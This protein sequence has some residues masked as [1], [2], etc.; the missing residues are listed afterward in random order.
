VEDNTERK[1]QEQKLA[2][3]TKEYETVFQGTQDAM[4]LIEAVGKTTF[5]YLRNNRAHAEATGFTLEEL[6][7]KTPQELLG[8]ELGAWIAAN[9]ARCLQEGGPISY[10]ETLSLPAGTKT[11]LTTLTPLVDDDGIYIVGASQDITARKEAEEK[12]RYLSFHDS[13]TGVYN[14]RF[15]EKKMC[16][17]NSSSKS[18]PISVVMADLNGLKLINDTYGH[19]KGDA[20]LKKAAEILK[21]SSRREDILG[22]WG[23]DEFVLILP[24]T[25]EEEAEQIIK[26]IKENARGVQVEEVPLSFALGF[27]AKTNTEE[28]LRDILNQA[29]EK[30]YRQ[31]LGESKSTRS[32]LLR[33]L[34][35]ALQDK[36]HK[37]K[38]HLESMEK[39][40]LKL[41][42]SLALPETEINRLK[43]L[44]L[45]H[46]I[47][48]ISVPEEIL[49]KKEALTEKEREIIKKHPETGYRIVRATEE[50]SHIAEDILSHHERW[51]GTGYPRK[52][53]GEEIPLLARI[54]MLVDAYYAL[55]SES[56]NRKALSEKE[57]AAELKKYAGS[58][59]D[60]KLVEILT[61]IGVTD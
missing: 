21:N 35:K 15:L 14:R 27:A 58:Q 51:D 26:R 2:K 34:L 3:I 22:R 52:L 9:Y 24:Q 12:I 60:P 11:W 49:N 10:E 23:G 13:L 36:G 54:I 48:M 31:K 29:E 45:L 1:L 37:P 38:E 25:K 59:F 40:A 19:E 50:F 20:L 17:L 53:K 39:L 6:K 16:S 46:D 18:L 47:G 43:L 30:M 56:P 8:E 5:R 32:A 44:V 57:A 4:F 33:R 41:A 28:N 7:G 61:A 42:E 55:I